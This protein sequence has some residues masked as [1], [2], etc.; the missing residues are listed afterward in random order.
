ME[1]INKLTMPTTVLL[2]SIILGGF[3]YASQISKQNSIE[4]QQRLEMNEKEKKDSLLK[5]GKSLCA[6]EA[7]ESA[8]EQYKN[9]CTYDCKDGYYYTT[10]YENYYETCLQRKGID[11]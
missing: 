3:Y 4:R 6:S 10:N 1:K 9:T 5:L 7:S 11:K 8:Q 2:A